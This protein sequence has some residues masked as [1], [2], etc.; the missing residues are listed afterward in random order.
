[1]GARRT[2]K[3]EN[4]SFCVVLGQ[5]H[6]SKIHDETIN[7]DYCLSHTPTTDTLPSVSPSFVSVTTSRPRCTWSPSS[8]LP[9]S[10]TRPGSSSLPPSPTSPTSASN[11]RTLI[12]VPISPNWW[13][14]WAC[15]AQTTLRHVENGSK[16]D[17]S[18]LLSPTFE[19]TRPTS[20]FVS[21]GLTWS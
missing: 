2:R 13:P 8:S 18:T 16:V 20:R 14:I 21:L 12:P 6:L 15:W 5:L 4:G 17:R 10:T 11:G 7:H 9:R 1:M 19:K 3:A